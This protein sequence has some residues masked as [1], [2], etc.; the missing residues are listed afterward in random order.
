MRVPPLQFQSFVG[1]PPRLVTSDMMSGCGAIQLP[2]A[3]A[4]I[5]TMLHDGT[6]FVAAIA[7]S[8]INQINAAIN[9][10]GGQINT[11]ISQAVGAAQTALIGLSA[12]IV[13]S[14]LIAMH[15]QISNIVNN[16]PSLA[17]LM[18]RA[19]ELHL[20]LGLPPL[21]SLNSV[22]DAIVNGGFNTVLN[23][24]LGAMDAIVTTI[25]SGIDAGVDAINGLVDGLSATLSAAVAAVTDTVNGMISVITNNI[26]AAL[27]SLTHIAS[28]AAMSVICAAATEL[29]GFINSITT[30][31]FQA[32]L[33]TP[34]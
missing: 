22:F 1:T 17:N 7:N 5:I 18:S 2:A 11:L 28:A 33:P 23:S 6:A 8:A 15:E 10:V 3:L 32:V 16:M 26:N 29:N 31:A 12:A 30:P 4:A 24:V 20:S 21:P 14:G 34:V 27:A 19:G 9:L 25:Q 13:N